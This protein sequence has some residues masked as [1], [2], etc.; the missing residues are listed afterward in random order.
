MLPLASTAARSYIFIARGIGSPGR[1]TI[2]GGWGASIS[3]PPPN[4]EQEQDQEQEG[5]Q[6]QEQKGK[7]GKEKEKKRKKGRRMVTTLYHHIIC[8]CITS[9]RERKK[10]RKKSKN[11]SP[12][13]R[14]RPVHTVLESTA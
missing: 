8:K 11:C 14:L 7:E 1:Y 12:A 13:R 9:F 6:E 3:S 5:K 4:P 2:G 10:E